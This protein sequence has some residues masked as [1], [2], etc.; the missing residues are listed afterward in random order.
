MNPESDLALSLRS[1]IDSVRL[2]Q[3]ALRRARGHLAATSEESNPFMDS[4]TKASESTERLLG[5]LSSYG[6]DS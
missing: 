1:A 6:A 4:L 5:L 3:D 2:A